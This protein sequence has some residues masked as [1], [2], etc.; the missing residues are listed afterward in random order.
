[1]KKKMTI[2]QARNILSGLIMSD[3]MGEDTG[4]SAAWDVV[5]ET[6]DSRS[7]ALFGLLGASSRALEDLTEAHQ[8]GAWSETDFESEVEMSLDE[9]EK[10]IGKGDASMNQ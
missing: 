7:Q 4:A 10:W 3:A 8:A 5:L 2:Q 9:L 1:M 6:L